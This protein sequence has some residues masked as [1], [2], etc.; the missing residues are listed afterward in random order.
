MIDSLFELSR[1][2]KN[3]IKRSLLKYIDKFWLQII[4]GKIAE[5]K[6]MIKLQNKGLTTKNIIIVD[7]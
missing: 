7:G 4:F 5:Q 3:L 1:K 2:M 6:V